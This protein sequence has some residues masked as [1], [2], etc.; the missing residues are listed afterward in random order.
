MK[1]S[2]LIAMCLLT[3]SGQAFAAQLQNTPQEMELKQKACQNVFSFINIDLSLMSPRGAAADVNVANS[4]NTNSNDKKSIEPVV[5]I[6]NK[7]CA[8]QPCSCP[9][10]ASVPPPSIPKQQ[11]KTSLFRIDLLHIFKIQVL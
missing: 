8:K 10:C 4:A 1:K 11:N 2:L 7:Q 6:S 9:S 5:P 3:L